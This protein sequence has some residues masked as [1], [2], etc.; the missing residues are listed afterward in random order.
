MS[1]TDFRPRLSGDLKEAVER[2]AKL[3]GI[4]ASE[5]IETAIRADLKTAT[6]RAGRI[7]GLKADNQLDRIDQFYGKLDH[8]IGQYNALLNKAAESIPKALKT[9][10]DSLKLTIER[11]GGTAH[12]RDL[13]KQLLNDSEQRQNARL[14]KLE[15]AADQSAQHSATR[16]A[17]NDLRGDRYRDRW[18]LAAGAGACLIMLAAFA[19]VF[20]DTAATRWAATR[21]MGQSS[22]V[23]A[24]VGL[25][26]QNGDIRQALYDTRTL[27]GS[28][29][30]FTNQFAKCVDRLV[31]AE[32]K[33][34]CQLEYT[35]PQKSDAAGLQ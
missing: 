13:L 2:A 34:T 16:A 19:F 22:S 7:A 18:L 32:R 4:S 11:T 28:S 14:S 35:P 10:F 29:E 30:D 1:E 25:I 12:L 5:L 21:L 6:S 24:G 3:R 26:S 23:L 31:K 20:A 15:S 9:E 8:V 27:L 33:Q 17:I